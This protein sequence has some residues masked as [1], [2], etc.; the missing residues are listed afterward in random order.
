MMRQKVLCQKS[1]RTSPSSPRRMCSAT[2]G[3]HSKNPRQ[4]YVYNDHNRAYPS[5]LL[6]RALV[7]IITNVS[8]AGKSVDGTSSILRAVGDLCFTQLAEVRHRGAFSAVAQTFAVLCQQCAVSQHEES[9]QLVAMWY[10]VSI[11]SPII[12]L[13][14]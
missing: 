10:N 12:S 9:R 8:N 11:E 2:H 3:E 7:V 13:S 14:H 4:F 5:S 6:V 1:L